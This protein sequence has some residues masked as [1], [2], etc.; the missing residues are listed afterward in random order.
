MLFAA[1]LF[2]KHVS[3]PN[4]ISGLATQ[5]FKITGDVLTLHGDISV[6]EDLVFYKGEV[7]G[8]IIIDGGVYKNITF[9]GGSFKTIIIKNGNFN[10]YVSICGGTIENLILRGGNFNWLGT[11]DGLK[12]SDDKGKTQLADEELTIKRF[13]IEGGTYTHNIWISGGTI[14]RLEVKCV[15]PVKIHCKPNDD[16]I[17]NEKG[18]YVQKY[19]SVPDIHTLMISRLATRDN[20]YHFSEIYL[21][22]LVFENFTNIG[23]I[24][25][26][27]VVLNTEIAFEKSDLG[28]TAFI[29]CD[30]S[31]QNLVF[32]S[33]KITEIALAGTQLPKG[34]KIGIREAL[35]DTKLSKGT[36][37]LTQKKLALGQ[38]KKV[39]QNMGD[40]V[41][42]A[43][44]QAEELN[45]YMSTLK[46]GG[47]KI[48]LLFNS[49][50]NKHGQSWVRALC[51][52]LGGSAIFYTFYCRA[53]GFKTDFSAQG[54]HVFLRNSGYL[55]EFINPIRKSEF[56][57][58][59]LLKTKNE[60][61]I[62]TIA[63]SIDSV[64]KLFN[65]YLIYQFI[66]AF[67]KHGKK[68]D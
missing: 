51:V 14:T 29:D 38:I 59:A 67:R 21:N 5:N 30:F 55:L 7:Y 48:N 2:K 43:E 32:D 28:K 25:I 37:N 27:K 54:F 17:L 42:A 1:S 45:T 16:Q 53:L 44:Y 13:E 58:K 40:S 52:L 66:A 33:S 11:L 47:E 46:C 26:A 56:L 10:G 31:E 50:S 68:S 49:W 23:I 15:T 8:N 22:V 35:K 19:D 41:K 6:L 24:T 62:L 36:N 12:N 64:S 61:A 18:E 34:A 20:F 9:R 3:N 65:A 63:Y 60:P 4:Q 39:Y 57:P